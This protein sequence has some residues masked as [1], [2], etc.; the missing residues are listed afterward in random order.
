MR[1]RLAITCMLACA[2]LVSAGG[3]AL[4]G[5]GV[6]KLATFSGQSTSAPALRARLR[7]GTWRVEHAGGHPQMTLRLSIWVS[8]PAGVILRLTLARSAAARAHLRAAR[9]TR[10]VTIGLG[11]KG[12]RS[13][14]NRLSVRLPAAISRRLASMRALR[15]GV[16][17]LVAG[18]R[19]RVAIRRTIVT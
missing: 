8:R 16:G 2:A 19:R 6:Q 15:V 1:R 13:G 9:G 10:Q 11:T 12:L 5:A 3:S 17:V 18:G 4:A 14:T 7:G